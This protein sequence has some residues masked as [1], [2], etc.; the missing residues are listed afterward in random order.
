[1]FKTSVSNFEWKSAG[2]ACNNACICVQIVQIFYLWILVIT[3]EE[4]EA[5]SCIVTNSDGTYSPISL[6]AE[7]TAYAVLKI[8][9]V[10]YGPGVLFNHMEHVVVGDKSSLQPGEYKY[11]QTSPSTNLTGMYTFHLDLSVPFACLCS[12]KI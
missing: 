9:K 12:F 10:G 7:K 8:L 11:L 3:S 6:P 2:N 5:T 4:M 1:M